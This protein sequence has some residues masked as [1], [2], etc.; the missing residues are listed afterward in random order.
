ME[1]KKTTAK[2]LKARAEAFVTYI[3]E[4]HKRKDKEGVTFACEEF[5]NMLDTLLNED[6][7]GTEGQCDPRGDRRG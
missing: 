6:F 4:L 2:T 3:V 5:D 7:F 1:P